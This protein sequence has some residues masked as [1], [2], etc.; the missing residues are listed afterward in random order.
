[1]S[2]VVVSSGQT[3]SGFVVSNG[4]SLTVLAGA[5]IVSTRVLDGGSA[6]ISSGG[7]ASAT[8]L[9]SGGYE[10]VSAAGI[11][12]RATISGGS[13]YVSAG[14]S[15]LSATVSAGSQVVE[16]GTVSGTIV[17]S[18]GLQAVYSGTAVGT[19]VKNGGIETIDNVSVA[20]GNARSVSATIS[21][22]GKQD[23]FHNSIANKAVLLRGGYEYVSGG[24]TTG[25]TASGGYEFVY[26]GGVASGTTLSSG[27]SEFVF[28]GGVVSGTVVSSGG[29][30]EIVGRGAAHG[31]IVK[32]SGK[33]LVGMDQ[34]RH[35]PPG[36]PPPLS[37][38]GGPLSVSATI[39]SG[40]TQYVYS[41]GD[42]SGTTVRSGGF[43]TVSYGG[44]S[45]SA[46]LL[47]GDAY[48]YS[49]GVASGTRV[50]RGA[51]LTVGS[52]GTASQV[53]VVGGAVHVST[54]GTATG[55][56]VGSGG[57]AIVQS[58]GIV[59]GAVIF[60]PKATLSVAGAAVSGLTLSGFAAT[61][62]LDLASFA[63]NKS[64][65]VSFSENAK[66]TQGV[67]TVNSGGLKASVTLFGQYAA[68]GFHLVND[69][70]G[71]A[72]TYSAATSAVRP[73]LAPGH[74]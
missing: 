13:Q 43:E 45:V 17:S 73:D 2:N 22:G 26:S 33:D 35:V 71:T 54:G 69:A 12:I 70:G 29:T 72:V 21:S 42:A 28:S 51:L 4:S 10:Y 34:Y 41:G 58:G 38:G 23:V 49:G 64:E 19:I 11:S 68:T 67:L 48:V 66:K 32:N 50:S 16:G 53:T 7:S 15:S 25:T 5:K 57:T 55:L 52:G 46:T 8:F 14:G 18:G 9:T 30:E 6:D 36:S 44:L 37:V 39:S 1:M 65:T 31:T 63:F 61:D 27:G 62:M 20:P 60:A 74:A 40:A 47:G 3:S 56:S 59:S 24:T